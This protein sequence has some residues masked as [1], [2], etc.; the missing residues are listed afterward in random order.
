M[1][2]DNQSLT[3]FS[4]LSVHGLQNISGMCTINTYKFLQ[5]TGFTCALFKMLTTYQDLFQTVSLEKCGCRKCSP[6]VSV[7]IIHCLDIHSG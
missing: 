5:S 4:G 2:M 1:A 7:P 6:K 3:S